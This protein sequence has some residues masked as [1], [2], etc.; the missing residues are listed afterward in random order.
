MFNGVQGEK[1]TG[2]AAAYV[3]E[4]GQD[5]ETMESYQAVYAC[6]QH[7]VYALAFW[8][9]DNELAAEQLMEKTFLR[10]FS[11]TSSPTEEMID[12]ALLK[13]I[14][15]L[16]PIGK[17]TLQSG[18]C[19]EVLAVRRHAK[20]VDLERAV[21]KLPA[22]ERLIYL[23]HDGEGYAHERIAFTLGISEDDSRR[24]LHQAR[25]GL[26]TLLAA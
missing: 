7:R 5:K 25:L 17:L 23:L 13:E 8:M 19:P 20:R 2:L 11:I 3:T 18:A 6:N 10:A 12:G 24:G 16:L 21:V 14:R 4:I 15:Q 1:F 26:R 22:T 9:T